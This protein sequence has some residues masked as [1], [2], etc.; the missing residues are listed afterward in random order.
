MSRTSSTEVIT[1]SRSRTV[2]VDIPA[3]AISALERAEAL[4]AEMT[5]VM[6]RLGAQRAD[7]IREAMATGM[8]QS[9]IARAL[10]VTPQAVNTILARSAP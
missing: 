5:T 6:A 9:A 4:K 3:G 1:V 8:S 2:T 7:A 10:G